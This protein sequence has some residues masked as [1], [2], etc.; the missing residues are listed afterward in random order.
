[1][2]AGILCAV[3]LVDVVRARFDLAEAI[4]RVA[5]RLRE[6]VMPFVVGQLAERV[7][8]QAAQPQELVYQHPLQVPQRA[9]WNFHGKYIDSVGESAAEDVY[10]DNH[11]QLD[12]SLSQRLTRRMRVFADF[13]NLTN[14]PLRYYLGVP[15]RPIQEEYYKWWATFGVKMNF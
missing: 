10:Y 2:A 11:T 8:V 13:L 1:M 7:A 5:R 6:Q 15:N 14:A 9:S 4:G 12:V 3:Q